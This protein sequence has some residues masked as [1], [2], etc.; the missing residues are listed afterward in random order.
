MEETNTDS[1]LWNALN[2][3]ALTRFAALKSNENFPIG[4]TNERVILSTNEPVILGTNERVILSTNE[5]AIL[6]TNE[7]V[8]L[9]TN[10]P[11]ILGTNG[12]AILSTNEPVICSTNQPVILGTKRVIRGNNRAAIRGNNQTIIHGSNEPA[13]LEKGI[14]GTVVTVNRMKHYAFLKRKDK[15]ESRDIF[16]REAPILNE[17]HQRKFFVADTCKFDIMKTQ[18][19]VEAVNI[20]IEE[21]NIN[22]IS[23]L[24]KI[25]K[26][27]KTMNN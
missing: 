10:E 6:G 24:P 8:I 18:R 13:I 15:I 2:R 27:K 3:P 1:T 7:R 25:P 22:S 12:R 9:S 16:A 11:A 4:G 14:K 26:K 23:K 5:P 19:G 20:K 21:R 17:I